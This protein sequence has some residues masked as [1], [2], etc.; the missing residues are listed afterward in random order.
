VRH[1]VAYVS[2]AHPWCFAR[3]SSI[4]NP[5]L[6]PKPLY[7]LSPDAAQALS[8]KRLAMQ[9]ED[10]VVERL[11]VASVSLYHRSAFATSS[12]LPVPEWNITLLASMY[13]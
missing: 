2:V 13:E 11:S 6:L 5:T 9:A 7:Q 12:L 1:V 3:V 10:L 4:F 8:H